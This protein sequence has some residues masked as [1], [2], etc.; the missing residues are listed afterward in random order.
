MVLCR[1]HRARRLWPTVEPR[2]IIV[3]AS[4]DAPTQHLSTM[5]C[6]FGAQ[7]LSILIDTLLLA[8]DQDSMLLQQAAH[9]SH[10]ALDWPA[11]RSCA[12]CMPPSS[13]GPVGL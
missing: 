2:V 11:G 6:V 7:K 10:C 13:S 3:G 1:L 4:A 12:L 8:S 5:N 9:L